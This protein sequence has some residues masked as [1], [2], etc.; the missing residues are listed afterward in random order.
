MPPVETLGVDAVQL[1]HACRE[2]SFGCFDEE[3]VMGGHEAVS[4]AEP[5]EIGDHPAENM[6]KHASTRVVEVYRAPGVPP[7][8]HMGDS[9][10]V[11]DSQRSGHD[12][13][14]HL[15]NSKSKT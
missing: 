3:M 14:I 13:A 5:I 7:G 6:Q 9:P 10:G 4:V 1:A 12:L 11:L 2:I 8:H 15:A